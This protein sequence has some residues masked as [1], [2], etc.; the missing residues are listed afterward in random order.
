MIEK[1]NTLKRSIKAADPT[2][3]DVVITDLY[4]QINAIIKDAKRSEKANHL[5]GLYFDK[6]YG[7]GLSAEEAAVD[8]GLT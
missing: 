1:L 5:Y 7:D 4:K 6:T 3:N 8:L 2:L